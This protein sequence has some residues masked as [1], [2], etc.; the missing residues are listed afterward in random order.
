MSCGIAAYGA[1]IPMT[2]L[3]LSLIGGRPPKDGGPEKAVAYYDEDSATMAV[4]A[5]IDCLRGF[6]RAEVD[7]VMFASTSYPLREKQGA[8]LIATALDLRPDVETADFTGSL[9]A[10]TDA[11]K[12]ALRAVAAGAANSILVVASDCR[13]AAPRSAMEQNL[14]DAAAAFLVRRVGAI[15]TLDATKAIANEMQDLWRSDGDDFVHTWEDRFVVEEGYVPSMVAA[16]RGL[17]EVTEK[18]I[19]QFDR[20]ALYAHDARSHATV[21]RKLGIDAARLQD[22]FQGRVGNCGAAYAPLLLCAALESAGVGERILLAGYGDGAEA[23]AMNVTDAIGEV[24]PRAGVAGHLERRRPLRSYDSYLRS[25]GLDK[26]EWEA[27]TGPGLSATIRMRERDADIGLVG[28]ACERCG[29]VHFPRP[30]VCYK[31]HAR[32]P[33]RRHRLSDKTGEI[34]AYTFDFFFPTPE[35]PAIMT[36]VD[37]D[38]CRVHIQLADIAPDQVRLEL[39]V[40]FTFRKIHEAG[41]KPNYFWKAVPADTAPSP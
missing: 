17:L 38:G 21:A 32:G 7:G 15:A 37:I 11:L 39:P 10:G 36:V 19:D 26:R 35:P 29:H 34:L 2:R 23:F 4:A 18:N 16:V 41:G 1:Y 20:V 13:M 40:R 14:G 12:A 33:W 3:P 22:T 9:R 30:Q 27:G 24:A 25:R 28:G 8:V 6:D 31:C 5:A